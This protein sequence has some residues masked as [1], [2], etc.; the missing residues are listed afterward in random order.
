M[1]A[2]FLP[3]DPRANPFTS[4][5][6]SP[7]GRQPSSIRTCNYSVALHL[8]PFFLKKKNPRP[9]RTLISGPFQGRSISTH[10]HVRV[11]IIRRYIYP[12]ENQRCRTE[13]EPATRKKFGSNNGQLTGRNQ[14]LTTCDNPVIRRGIK[15]DQ[16]HDPLRLS[17][18]FFL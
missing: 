7:S 4:R 13:T 8:A 17:F 15:T 2:L 9:W 6:P 16:T 18:V 10:V 1:T 11:S 14:L 5:P 12:R 3:I